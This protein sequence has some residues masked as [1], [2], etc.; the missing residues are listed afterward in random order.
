M[1]YEIASDKIQE[2]ELIKMEIIDSELA[3][4][5]NNNIRFKVFLSFR[6][7]DDFI[8]RDMIEKLCELSQK[9]KRGI[10]EAL[11]K[12]DKPVELNSI[13]RTNEKFDNVFISRVLDK[14]ASKV[15]ICGP[16]KFNEVIYQN[17]IQNGIQKENIIL[18]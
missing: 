11:V 12:I 7:I 5:I 2:K 9:T 6:E 10:F 8:G 16:P 17:S 18:V 4:S 3:R 1:I 14:N 13:L 15:Y